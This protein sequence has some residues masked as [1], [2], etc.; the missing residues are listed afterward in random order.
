IA[1]LFEGAEQAS[2]ARGEPSPGSEHFVLAA[3]SLSDG[4]AAAA[5]RLLGIDEAAFAATLAA[6]DAAALAAIGVN[7]PSE[8][9]PS[10]PTPPAPRLFNTQPSA[11]QLMQRMTDAQP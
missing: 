6:Q 10:L 8:P 3:L 11:R 7:V 4:T 5:F 1:R 2:R 9:Q